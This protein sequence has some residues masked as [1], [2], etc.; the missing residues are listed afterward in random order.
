M[1]IISCLIVDDDDVFVK[2]L[3]E[4]I[5][6]LPFIKVAAS[7]KT[8]G[9]TLA[10]LKSQSIDVILLDVNLESADGLN[11]F[12]L[13]RQ[14]PTLPPV[15][16][17]SNTP[18]HA[19]ESYN[20]GKAKDFM[21]KPIDTRRLL[22]AFNRAL[23]TDLGNGS[24]FDKN[25]V[26]LKMGRKFQRFDLDEIDYIEGYGIYAKVMCNNFSH[27]VNDSLVNL[28]TILDAKK[29]MRVH[30]SYIINLNKLIGFEHNKLFLKNGAVPIGSSYK[31]RLEGLLRLFDNQLDPSM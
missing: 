20:I 29:F 5:E 25:S 15:V 17:I 11:G 21:V 23:D 6:K 24:M 26:F 10:A 13:L 22:L 9:E 12:D 1:Q 4:Q 14:Y 27:V 2:T 31:A 3:T 7:C 19:V 30:K 28:E 18:E 8:Y 16:V